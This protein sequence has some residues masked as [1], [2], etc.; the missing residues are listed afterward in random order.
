MGAFAQSKA[1][2]ITCARG[3]MLQMRQRHLGNLSGG[4]GVQDGAIQLEVSV[5]VSVE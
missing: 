1:A 2:M 5:H 4:C 3:W